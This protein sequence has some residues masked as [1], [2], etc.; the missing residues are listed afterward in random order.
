MKI[1]FKSLQ[2]LLLVLLCGCAYLYWKLSPE[3]PPA[4]QAFINANVITVDSQDS[5]YEAALVEGQTIIAVGS[6]K[7]ITA[8]IQAHADRASVRVHDLSGKT[9]MPGI[10]DAHSHF[11]GSGVYQ[12]AADLNSPP[13]GLIRNIDELQNELRRLSNQR[14]G[15]EW[16]F[17]L[18]YDDSQMEE[19]R[20]PTRAELDAVS[21]SRPIFILHVSGHMGVVNSK[22]LELLE[23][24][25]DSVPPEG[26]AYLKNEQGELTGLLLETAA[27]EALSH[28]ADFSVF[29][30]VDILKKATQEYASQGITSAQNGAADRKQADGLR[31]ASK[32]GLTKQRLIVWPLQDVYTQQDLIEIGRDNTDM[33]EVGAIKLVVDGSIQ[34]Y[35]G[36][37]SKPYHVQPTQLL[38]HHQDDD[39]K[40]YRGKPLIERN[41]LVELVSNYFS[42]GQRLAIHGNGDAAIDDILHAVEMA[43]KKAP[44]FDHRTVL[45][46]GQMARRDQLAKMKELGVVP[47]FFSAHTYYWGDRHRRLF[48][49]RA[50]ADG[51]SPARSAQRNELRYSIHLD[52]PV[53]PMQTMRLL[54]TAVNRESSSGQIIGRRERISR[55]QAIRAVTINAAYQVF[56]EA[57]LGSI[58]VGKLADFVVLDQDPTDRKIDLL[59]ISILSTFVGGV[60]IYHKSDSQ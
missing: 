39:N 27:L 32:L 53:V 50:R 31:W 18:G 10:I 5:R 3:E 7:E 1:V 56:K 59:D 6:T 21:S 34:G 9:L 19:S 46:H 20:H 14:P 36:Y 35:T 28:A 60:R 33:F 30:I 2:V 8:L 38:H 13:I 57:S 17:G 52:T 23:I 4:L 16:L 42:T 49:G 54:W 45:V 37:L 12:F 55:E 26:G 47:S 29:E 22:G 11:P 40:A 51:M 15:N 43:L 48:M 41:A 58:E 24:D 25:Q 44:E